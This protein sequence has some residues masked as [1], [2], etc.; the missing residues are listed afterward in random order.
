VVSVRFVPP[1]KDSGHEPAK[2]VITVEYQPV[3]WHTHCRLKEM[4]LRGAT[5]EAIACMRNELE[6]QTDKL[7]KAR[8][9]RWGK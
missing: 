8:A 7:N 4:A 1:R 5:N 3:G 6:R 9:K 2:P